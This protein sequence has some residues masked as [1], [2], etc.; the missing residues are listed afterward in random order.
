MSGLLF[1]ALGC[2]WKGEATPIQYYCIYPYT[3]LLLVLAQVCCLAL[4]NHHGFLVLFYLVLE[5]LTLCTDP[6][7]FERVPSF[8]C[9]SW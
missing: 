4:C 6:L 9:S 1:Y 5:V 8:P 3:P 2:T 7:D